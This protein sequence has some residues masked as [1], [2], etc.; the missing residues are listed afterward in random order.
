LE[1]A[2]VGYLGALKPKSDVVALFREIVLDVWKSKR[3]DAHAARKFLERKVTDL[4]SK[5]DRLV[6]AFVYRQAID[7]ATYEEQLDKLT[8]DITLA[9]ME[10]H[11]ASLDEL[12]VEGVLNFAEHVLL[13]TSRLW[14]ECSLEQKQRLQS[15]LFPKGVT[16]SKGAFGT[17]ELS[18]IFRM[19]HLVSGQGA[20]DGDKH[21]KEAFGTAES[22]QFLGHLDAVQPPEVKRG[23]P[24]GI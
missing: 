16:Y 19:L 6:D 14:V 1:D 23:V 18:R 4:R 24:D 17:T 9:E 21:R 5:K 3:T 22:T 15:I 13:N 12:D 8:E 11:D 10:L 7:A 20:T 2:F